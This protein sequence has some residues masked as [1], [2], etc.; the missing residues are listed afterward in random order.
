LASRGRRNVIC[1]CDIYTQWRWKTSRKSWQL[2]KSETKASTN[3]IE[4]VVAT[5]IVTTV[6]TTIE[7]TTETVMTE[8]NTGPDIE[9]SARGGVKETDTIRKNEG[10]QD[11]RPQHQRQLQHCLMM[12]TKRTNG[13][14]RTQ[15]GQ[16]G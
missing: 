3:A 15:H 6:N 16:K 9:I 7:V 11:T 10:A 8:T 4:A 1:N 13:S 5:G 2:R 12:I 14:R